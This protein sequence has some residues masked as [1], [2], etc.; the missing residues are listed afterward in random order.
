MPDLTE[1]R[2]RCARHDLADFAHEFLRRNRRYRHQFVAISRSPDA[3]GQAD[4][5]RDLARMWGLDFR[6]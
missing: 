5:M 6:I 3:G 2:D 1:L 4:T